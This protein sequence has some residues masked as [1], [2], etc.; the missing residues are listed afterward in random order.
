MKKILI[1][2][3]F[4]ILVGCSNQTRPI[5]AIIEPP[6]TLNYIDR[7]VYYNIN[8]L[9]QADKAKVYNGYLGVGA[10]AVVCENTD[11][12]P[13]SD[14]LDFVENH[15]SNEYEKPMFLVRAFFYDGPPEWFID[16]DC[17]YT[18]ALVVYY[19]DSINK[20]SV[21]KIYNDDYILSYYDIMDRVIYSDELITVVDYFDIYYSLDTKE[22]W[23]L[24]LKDKDIVL[25]EVSMDFVQN[26]L[27]KTIQFK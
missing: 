22:L 4:L 10:D 15:E 25:N 9:S 17:I 19:T 5:P 18:M 14:S 23:Y 7:V 24:H 13:F 11:K 16:M 27:L 8:D 12:L 3:L 26:Y 20:N 1:T 2:A 21:V 6:Y